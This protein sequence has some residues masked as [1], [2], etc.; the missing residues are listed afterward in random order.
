MSSG[1][2]LDDIIMNLFTDI[3]KQT[4][5]SHQKLFFPESR[6]IPFTCAKGSMQDFIWR[7][8]N[9]DTKSTICSHHYIEREKLRK[10]LSGNLSIE[11]D[12]AYLGKKTNHSINDEVGYNN[13]H[14]IRCNIHPISNLPEEP[15][16]ISFMTPI[17]FK[18]GQDESRCY[19]IPS[20]F[21]QNLF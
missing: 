5:K 17:G 19:V 15:R 16:F 9:T 7:R 2:M 4:T 12:E 3:T 14:I 11:N 20:S 6:M 21:F 1:L 8:K 18:S 13:K 10:Y